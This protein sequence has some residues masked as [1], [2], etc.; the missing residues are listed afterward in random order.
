[1]IRAIVMPAC[2]GKSSFHQ[3]R[4]DLWDAGE[5]V[6]SKEVLRL[7]RAKARDLGD[8]NAFDNWWVESMLQ[9]LEGQ[10]AY[11]M[12]PYV[13]IAAHLGAPIHATIILPEHTVLE[14]LLTRPKSG[15]EFALSS[16]IDALEH[17]TNI[18]RLEDYNDISTF[19][20]QLPAT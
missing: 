16:R 12:I 20:K 13:T 4:P 10:N 15:I 14:K 8:W 7:K 17:S 6:E 9:T 18:I 5:L 1:M 2:H 19:L 3:L 11:V